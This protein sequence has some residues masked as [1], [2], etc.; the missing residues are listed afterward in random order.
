MSSEFSLF[1]CYGITA[2]TA[3]LFGFCHVVAL[4]SRAL[5]RKSPRPQS[6]VSAFCVVCVVQGMN[7]HEGGVCEW[8]E[9]GGADRKAYRFVCLEC[10][11]MGQGV[12]ENW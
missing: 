5:R 3:V 7:M 9:C 8:L 2:V 6:R 12:C 1:L 10:V 4:E 11:T